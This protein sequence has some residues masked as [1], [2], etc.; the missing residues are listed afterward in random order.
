VTEAPISAG[1]RWNEVRSRTARK[2]DDAAN[3]FPDQSARGAGRAGT[4]VCEGGFPPRETKPRE[5]DPAQ[6]GPWNIEVAEAFGPSG[7][8]LG[9]EALSGAEPNKEPGLRTAAVGNDA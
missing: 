5:R 6:E 9:G 8:E 7:G 3:G 4:S 2:G 1:R